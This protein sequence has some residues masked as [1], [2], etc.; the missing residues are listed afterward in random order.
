M[1]LTI[2]WNLLRLHVLNAWSKSRPLMSSAI[3][4]I[5]SEHCFRFARILMG[6]N[7][8]FIERTRSGTELKL[9]ELSEMKIGCDSP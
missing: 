5:V 9:A 8:L 6:K 1:M 3:I 7:L 4:I 2:R